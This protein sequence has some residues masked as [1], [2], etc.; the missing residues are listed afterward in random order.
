MPSILLIDDDTQLGP[1][2]AAYFARF[3]MVLECAVA[4]GC[5]YIVTHNVKDFRRS[6]QLGVKAITPAVFLNLLKE[7]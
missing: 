7:M 6:E 4:A 3:D 5:Q 1:P 2:L